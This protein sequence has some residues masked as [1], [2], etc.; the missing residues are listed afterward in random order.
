MESALATCIKAGKGESIEE[1][2]DFMKELR[3]AQ[4]MKKQQDAEASS[5]RH[6]C[7]EEIWNVLEYV[8]FPY[9][10]NVRNS[11]S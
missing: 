11:T 3:I 7:P 2:D 8:Y 4:R 10:K 1:D 5:L 9:K 6:K